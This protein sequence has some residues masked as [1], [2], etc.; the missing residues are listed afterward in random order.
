VKTVSEK[1][2]GEASQPI[3]RY[4]YQSMAAA[5]KAIENSNSLA[6]IEEMTLLVTMKSIYIE[7]KTASS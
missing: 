1:S 5:M 6:A 3:N 7:K 4:Q 2:S